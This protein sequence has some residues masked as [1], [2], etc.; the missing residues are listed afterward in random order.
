MTTPF[1]VGALLVSDSFNRA[2]SASVGSTDGG[3]LGPLAWTAAVDAAL[4]SWKIDSNQLASNSNG[5]ALEPMW[6]STGTPDARVEVDVVA[7]P[8]WGANVGL[9]LRGVN[10]NNCFWFGIDFF[11]T[12]RV[13]LQERDSLSGG[14]NNLIVGPW[15]PT[16]PYTLRV[17]MF[18]DEFSCYVDN[19]LIAT[20]TSSFNNTIGEHGC[21]TNNDGTG[22]LDNFKVWELSPVLGGGA[23]QFRRGRRAHIAGARGVS[24]QGR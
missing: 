7:L 10:S 14:V 16:P 3:S 2:N 17:D 22:R 20:V 1:V 21:W 4:S 8:D 13:Y 18:G 9:V 12:F 15:F 5:I 19:V 11:S 23:Y 6:V 24:I